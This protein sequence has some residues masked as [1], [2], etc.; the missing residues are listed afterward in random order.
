[1]EVRLWNDEVP[2]GKLLC[3]WENRSITPRVGEVV[4]Y[5]GEA[6]LVNDVIHDAAGGPVVL[7][8]KK[9]FMRKLGDA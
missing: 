1:M 4:N 9:V 3:G 5:A 8:C 2:G 6:W 7:T